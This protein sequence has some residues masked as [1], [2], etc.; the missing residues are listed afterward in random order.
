MASWR[1]TFGSI[2][3]IFVSNKA[4]R[5][6]IC[7]NFGSPASQIVELIDRRKGLPGSWQLV[8]C[9]HCHVIALEPIPSEEELATYYAAY[10]DDENVDLSIKMGSRRP[11]LRKV[12]H[13]L[14]GDVDP[15]DF[16][17]VRTGER[18]LDYGCGHAGYLSDFHHRGIAISGAEIA[19]YVVQACQK[20]GFDVRQVERFSHIP[21]GDNEFDVVYLMQVF[22]H[23]REPHVFMQELSRVL[24]SGGTLYLAVPNI[25]SV[26]RKVFGKNWVSGWFAPFHLFHYSRVSLANLAAQHGFDL[27]DSWSNTP[28]SWFRLNLKA[29]IHPAENRLDWRASWLDARPVR[30]I[31]MLLLRVI[32]IPVRERDCLVVKLIKR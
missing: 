8:E 32:E 1:Y 16:V 29:W 19:G 18:V 13:R 15:R 7:G 30:Y 17:Q 28:E 23:L 21:F 22:E 26:W 25:N 27:E 20:R 10:S 14:T 2:K 5:C 9:N 4:Y 11:W 24:K 12:F 6:V 31:S 3:K